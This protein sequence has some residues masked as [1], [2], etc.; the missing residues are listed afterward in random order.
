MHYLKLL[1]RYQKW[2]VLMPMICVITVFFLTKHTKKAYISSTTLY[3]GVASGYSIT[4]T[5]DERLDYFAVNNAFDNL[6]ASAKSRETIEQVA[7]HLLAEHLLVTRPDSQVLSQTG[8]DNLRKLAGPQLIAHARRL[9]DAQSVYNYISGIYSS[10]ADNIIAEILDQPSTFY[11]IDELKTN[12]VVTRINTSD[13]LQIDYSC[14]DPAVCLRTLE[15][16]TSIF[17]ANYKQLKADQTYSAVH[18][19][20]TKLTE[21]RA[22]LAASEDSLKQFGQKNRIINY[23]E[24]T[25][26]VAQ[27]KEDLDKQIFNEKI[28]KNGSQ[29]TLSLIQSKLHSRQQQVANGVNLIDLRQHIS[30]VNSNLERAKLYDN[31]EKISE[32]TQEA[33]LLG[34][35]LKA[36]SNQYMNLNY[37]L[38]TVPRS[39]LMAQ[40]V[41]N[42]VDADKASAGLKV[43]GTQKQDY[44]NEFDQLAPL[45]STLKQLDRQADINEKEY[46]AVLTGLHL[47][48]LRQNN[49]NLN[50]NIVIQDKPYFP[51]KPQPSTRALMIILSFFVGILM[52]VSV[53]IGREKM[54]SSVRSPERAT[55]IIN[56][57]L[58]GVSSR[59]DEFNPQPYQHALRTLLVEKF[60][61]SVFS[62]MPPA[63]NENAQLQMMML[64]TKPGVFNEADI[65]LTHET[66]QTVFIDVCWVVPA[67]YSDIFSKALSPASFKV[68]TAG[69]NQLNCKT[70]R[71]LVG[72]DLSGKN[73]VVWLTPDLSSHSLPTS[74][75]RA[76]DMAV[77]AFKAD[78]TWLPVDKALISTTRRNM[79]DVPFFTWLIGTDEAN[80]DSLIGEIPKQRSWLKK[81]IKK[82]LTLNLK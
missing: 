7:L 53:V 54:D 74:I 13:M 10:K 5:E 45:G 19:F 64:T 34:D 33:Q 67:E 17:T 39:S 78:D 60:V 82:I 59:Y 22:K 26:Y 66:L 15:L 38:E 50:S 27:A 16:H 37:T 18:Y 28:A 65:K 40:W 79:P 62:K 77:L 68:Y 69:I 41:D 24:Q 57:P 61:S 29:Q 56:L 52:V 23:Y 31:K 73:M 30:E 42:A 4:S 81:K 1:L 63:A 46:L 75:A 58:L 43:M 70:V 47:A 6:V 8:F 11:N 55:Q 12:L 44:L 71:D 25:R 72:E 35:S 48:T 49:L 51:L 3:T 20:E 76:S 21:A 14:T 9:K 32:Y 36:A 2:L 80:L